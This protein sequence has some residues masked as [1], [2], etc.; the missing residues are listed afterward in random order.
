M[1]TGAG[2]Y[3]G[4][5]FAYQALE[6]DYDVLGIDNFSNSEESSIIKLASFDKFTFKNHDLNYDNDALLE[7][8]SKFQP[9]FVVHFAGLKSVDESEH[10]P[11]LYWRNNL[12]ATINLVEVMLELNLTKLIFSSSATIY[13]E[14]IIQPI[15]ESAE[16]K[17]IS[18]YGSTKIA[19]EQFLQDVSKANCLDVISLRYFNPI[20]SHKKKIIFDSPFNKPANLMPR[21]VRVALGLDQHINIYGNDYD[22]DDGTCERDFIHV[23]DLI[24]GHFNA[25]EYLKTFNGF[26]S[27]N[28]GTGHSTSVLSLISTFEET[29][30]LKLK[31]KF[32]S[33]RAGDIEVCFADP[34]KAKKI[35]NWKAERTIA[36]MCGDSWGAV[37]ELDT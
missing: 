29:C 8:V 26:D 37:R 3:L 11:I 36:D 31:K 32:Q 12:T 15:P 28:L 16:L 24:N 18:P 25:V 30:N 20:G 22:T 27:F 34:Q 2:G 19:I 14:S 13:G 7:I 1:V 4:A 21:L 10:N 35:L 17:S 23:S 6:K 9:D 5:T 33:R